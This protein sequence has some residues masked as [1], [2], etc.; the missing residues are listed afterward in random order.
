MTKPNEFESLKSE[1]ENLQLSVALLHNLVREILAREEPNI[2][3]EIMDKATKIAT[4]R[5]IVKVSIP[6][7]E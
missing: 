2:R 5:G 6:N 7:E 1:V 4:F 3:D